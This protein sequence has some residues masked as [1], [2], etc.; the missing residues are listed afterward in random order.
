MAVLVNSILVIPHRSGEAGQRVTAAG[1]SS[2]QMIWSTTAHR[3][4][5][6]R[7]LAHKAPPIVVIDTPFAASPQCLLAWR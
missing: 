7:K 2:N 3:P 5:C 6:L 1:D 4:F